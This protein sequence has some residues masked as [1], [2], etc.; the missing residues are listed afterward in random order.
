MLTIE[1]TAKEAFEAWLDLDPD[2][3]LW[4]K[5]RAALS[6]G[7]LGNSVSVNIEY[8][9]PPG[10]KKFNMTI[11]SAHYTQPGW[12]KQMLPEGAVWKIKEARL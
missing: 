10:R 6:G 1:L 2:T 8:R 4:E 7:G 3:M 9:F 5:L 12:Y 11:S